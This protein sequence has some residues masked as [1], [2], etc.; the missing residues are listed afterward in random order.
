MRVRHRAFALIVVLLAVAMVFVLGVRGAVATRSAII[1]A[2]VIGERVRGER[3]ARSA[4]A[5][6][7][8]GLTTPEDPSRRDSELVDGSGRGAGTSVASA[9]PQ[10]EKPKEIELPEIIKQMLGLEDEELKKGAEEASRAGLALT[11]GGG[12]TGRARVP[13]GFELL[14]TYGLPGVPVEVDVGGTRYRVTLTD[15][16]GLLNINKAPED[17]MFRF[18]RLHGVEESR[19]RA[20]AAQITDWRDTDDFKSE[21]GAESEQYTRR[22]LVCR[23]GPFFALEEMLYLPSMTPEVFEQVKAG[24]CVMGDGL[25]HLASAPREV[26]ES[27]EGMT[28]DAVQLIVRRR[29]GGTLDEAAVG[30][31][32]KTAWDRARAEVRM[33]P[34]AVVRVLVEPVWR[35]DEN[36]VRHAVRDAR[37][38]A[39]LGLMSDQG[40]K[41]LGLRPL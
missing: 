40:L 6:V 10:S 9:G 5:L 18:F 17:R 19:A 3:D 26:L 28:A 39:G 13:R 23:N 27:I 15:A 33:K 2:R 25:A 4:A 22:G 29:E 36:G 1:E 31:A 12:L 38:F 21:Y 41:E 35:L 14:Q 8:R 11:D 37:A 34:S 32:M 20:I 30:E 24:L 7:L 16:A